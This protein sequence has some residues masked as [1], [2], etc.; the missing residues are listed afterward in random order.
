MIQI[1]DVHKRYLTSRGESVWAL[2]G[3]SVAIPPKVNVAILGKHGS[4]KSTLLR[5]IAGI[6]RPTRG[7]ILCER[8]V[9]WPIGLV[10]GLQPNLSGRQNTRFIARLQGFSEK[11]IDKKIEF[12]IEF[13]EIGELFEQPFGTYSNGMRARLNF[14]LSVAFEFDVY[15]VDEN[16][17]GG[18]GPFL[19]KTR[20]TIKYLS[21][22]ADLIVVTHA[23]NILKTYCEAAVWLHEGRAHWFDSASEAWQEHKKALAA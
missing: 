15:L 11:E 8:R 13:C 7:E 21:E 4:G 3:I 20:N 5:L 19:E 16:L 2:R 22:H 12:V 6:D 14:A 23:E 9:S 18:T 1:N 17:G 10:T